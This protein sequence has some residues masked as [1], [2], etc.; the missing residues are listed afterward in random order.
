MNGGR[1]LPDTLWLC[2]GELNVCDVR[3][4]MTI[5]LFHICTC[6][7]AFGPSVHN[8]FEAGEGMWK[9]V[10]QEC[11]HKVPDFASPPR[12]PH[13]HPCLTKVLL[14]K[15]YTHVYVH[16]QFA[17]YKGR[18]WVVRE[19]CGECQVSHFVSWRQN[20]CSKSRQCCDTA[21]MLIHAQKAKWT[22]YQMSEDILCSSLI[23]ATYQACQSKSNILTILLSRSC[24]NI[25]FQGM[26][27]T[28][29]LI[30]KFLFKSG[31]IVNIK[32]HTLWFAWLLPT[33]QQYFD[34]LFKILTS[35]WICFH[36]SPT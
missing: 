35:F 7:F 30:F 25:Q 3:Y 33:P 29:S 10:A 23:V 2:W 6:L 32:G 36:C 11:E 22:E 27:C 26:V 18:V 19:K 34:S 17:E 15:V 24:Q 28:F 12:H 31:Q 9:Y 20:L 1:G 8:T 4:K 13:P 14:T 16:T 5:V 21:Q